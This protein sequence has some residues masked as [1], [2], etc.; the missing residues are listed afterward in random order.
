MCRSILWC[1]IYPKTFLGNALYT[2]YSSPPYSA[3]PSASCDV[4]IHLVACTTKSAI[5]GLE[6]ASDMMLTLIGRIEKQFTVHK[7][8][9]GGPWSSFQLEFIFVFPHR[10][11]QWD[12]MVDRSKADYPWVRKSLRFIIN[13]REDRWQSC[14]HL[15]EAAARP[16]SPL[17]I[18]DFSIDWNSFYFVITLATIIWDSINL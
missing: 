11:L 9:G 12:C 18:L 10:P 17:F 1:D 7:G 5:W 4:S 3:D 15:R 6:Y 14:N 16:W 8:V 2:S 13:V